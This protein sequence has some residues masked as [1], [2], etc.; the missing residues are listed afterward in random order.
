MQFVSAD[1][2]IIDYDV[3]GTGPPVL[4]IHGFASNARVNW[5][6]TGWVKALNHAG[7]QAITFDNRGHGRSGKLYE[8][9]FYGGDVMAEDARRLIEHVGLRKAAAVGY[10][11]GARIAAE[12]T[13]RCPSWVSAAVFGG[14]ATNM[15]E[16][17]AR[18]EEIAALLEMDRPP[19]GV[20]PDVRAY[21][22]FAEQTGSDLKALA[23][24]LRASRASVSLQAL[25]AIKVP[26][27]V[28]A[29]SEDKTAG[30]VQPLVEAI[31]GARGLVLPG[32]DHMKA[33][34]DRMFKEETMKFLGSV[35]RWG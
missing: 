18:T 10:S 23:A 22:S 6:E 3:W 15:I 26:V 9:R 1:D 27:L 29:G 16:G 14:L 17:L 34:G 11:M 12:L 24:C 4:L 21:R 28:V 2:V 31:P 32:R 7:Y 25:Q 19:P 5:I 20:D 30:A 35:G 33:V 13:I 8:P